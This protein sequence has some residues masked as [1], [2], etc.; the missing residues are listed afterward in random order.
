MEMISLRRTKD[1]ALIELP[2]KTVETCF[3]N[4]SIEERTFYDQ[5]ER[6]AKYHVQ[7]CMKDESLM[8][9]YSTVLSIILRL[10]QICISSVLCPH[11]LKSIL[12]TGKIGGTSISVNQ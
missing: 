6:E 10:R 3:V 5:M 7:E 9:S 12:P 1:K 4:L 11:D 2:K 8:R